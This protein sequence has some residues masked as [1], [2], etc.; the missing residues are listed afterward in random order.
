MVLLIDL[1]AERIGKTTKTMGKMAWLIVLAGKPTVK[2]ARKRRKM[3][4]PTGFQDL[5]T[6]SKVHHA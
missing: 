2:T 1:K 5:R 3:A 6:A 4:K